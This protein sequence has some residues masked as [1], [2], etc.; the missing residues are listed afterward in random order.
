M[1]EVESVQSGKRIL[2][3]R[4]DRLGDTL[5]SL[6]LLDALKRRWP[7]CAITYFT[8]PRGAAVFAADPRIALLCE[9]DLAAMPLADKL[10]VGVWVRRRGFDM[11]F[12]LKEHPWASY[13]TWMSN[14]PVCLG[15][16]PGWSQPTKSLQRKLAFTASHVYRTRLDRPSLHEVERYATLGRL[17]GCPDADGPLRL[18]LPPA[19]AS[20]AERELRPRIPDG[21]PAPLAF[22]LSPKWEG[23]GWD[24]ETYL[25]AI[26][27]IREQFPDR[28]LVV[29]AGLDEAAL[30]AKVKAL[31][32]PRVLLFEGLDV[33]EWAA[34]LARCAAL[35]SMDTGAVH[36]AASVNTPVIDIFPARNCASVS[37]R[38]RP[39]MVPQ[40]V[41]CRPAPEEESRF[42]DEICDA[43][44]AL[45]AETGAAI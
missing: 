24:G 29:T 39:W 25:R 37:S 41:L 27:A 26:K 33:P 1:P 9:F 35:V 5:L 6:P 12:C 15:L 11:V 43:L 45:L 19:A 31:A 40:R 3:I 7:D 4:L 16:D 42:F 38:W 28:C 22:H 34:L 32:D 21:G 14:A 36:L 13:W 44:A 17:A 2:L 30:T 10:G 18:A 23:E 8:S 20:W